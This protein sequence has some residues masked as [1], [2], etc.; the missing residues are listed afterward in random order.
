MEQ[1]AITIIIFLWEEGNINTKKFHLINWSIIR[2]SKERGGIAIKDSTLMNIAMG[3]K[4]LWRLFTK[5]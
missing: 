5:T 2:S 1:V 4:I 3:A